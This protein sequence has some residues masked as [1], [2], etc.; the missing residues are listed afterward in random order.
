MAVWAGLAALATMPGA[1]FKALGR[2]WLLTATGV[3]QM[4]IL[5]PAIWFAAPHGIAAVAAVQV[6]EK[7]VS[8]TLLGV[9]TG[10][11]LGLRWYAS[12]EAA[13][14]A[15]GLSAL[16]G[17]TLYGLTLTV[18]PGAALA[19]GI[20]LGAGLY[21]VLLRQVVPDG[22]G[23]LARPLLDLRRRLTVPAGMALL[24]VVGLL[25]AGCGGADGAAP[26]ASKPQRASPVR[27]TFYV[28]PGG[29][30]SGPGSRRHPFGTIG[31][32]LRR[33]R[34]GQRLYLRGG[35]YDER[36]KLV[37]APGRRHARIRVSNYPGER[38]V[39][40]GQIWIG[41]PSYWT[42]RGLHVE[43]SEANPD[44]PL[45]RIYGG[46]GWRLTRSEIW[47]S[48]STSGLQVDDGP[49]NNLGRWLVKRN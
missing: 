31:H 25:F 43:W 2:S 37:A 27:H 34:Y 40:H 41:D 45:V 30:D 6:G 47:G 11:V 1:V 13:A 24:L 19:I 44:E 3:M 9:I 48:R 42:I 46:T 5:F 4:A 7:T 16:M 39:L 14:P 15:L 21:L 36:V 22:F 49:R 20:P 17:A 26:A 23:L 10:R 18:P 12:F 32:A 33:L 8:L 29:S 35:T 38:P 28:A